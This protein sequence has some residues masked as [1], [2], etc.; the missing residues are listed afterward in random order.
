MDTPRF[1]LLS[2]AVSQHLERYKLNVDENP[3]FVVILFTN[4]FICCCEELIESTVTRLYLFASSQVRPKLVRLHKIL[5]PLQPM[6]CLL[7]L[8]LK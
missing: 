7:C 3:S 8:D 1:D 6:V 2:S 4:C 5:H